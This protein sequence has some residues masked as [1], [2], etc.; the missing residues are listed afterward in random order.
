MISK[1][2]KYE[3]CHIDHNDFKV[4]S[5]KNE[6]TLISRKEKI[7]VILPI[8]FFVSLFI[9]FRIFRRLTRLDKMSIALSSSGLIIF[10]NKFLYYW[11]KN[12]G[13]KLININF[14]CRSLMHNSIGKVDDQTFIFGEY[15]Q[16]SKNGKY[17]YKTTDGG[18]SW[19]AVF[20]FPKGS[21]RHI[22]NCLWDPYLKK[23]WVFTGDEDHESKVI[24]FTLDFKFKKIFS[25]QS[26]I[27]RA[28]GA[29]IDKNFLYWVTD[30]PNQPAVLVKFNKKSGKY[31]LGANFSG[32]AYYYCHT[33]DRRYYISTAVEPGKSLKNNN[34]YIY[35]SKNLEDWFPVASFKHDGLN[36]SLF[37]YATI[38][39]PMGK[40][41]SENLTLS[42]DAVKKFDGQV[43]NWSST[44][45][46]VS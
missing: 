9:R 22:H 6:I 14:S 42:F 36:F 19:K 34:A 40:F 27:F 15:G 31:T 1:K 3:K 38:M 41:S 2:L 43:V 37:R 5:Y 39:F 23:I 46:K 32:P 24:A 29:F 17:I 4:F 25:N 7:N 16:P 30:T 26:Q 21:I 13:L 35:E 11:N 44:S 28:T 33:L 45:A 18:R 8:N 20:H 10:W 12:D